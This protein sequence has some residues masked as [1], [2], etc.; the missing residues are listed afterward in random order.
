MDGI[1][2]K[3]EFMEDEFLA[4]IHEHKLLKAKYENHPEVLSDRLELR[5]VQEELER[6]RN[7]FDL[8]ERDVLLEEVQVLRSQ[9]QFYLDFSP[10]SSRK[11]NSLH[12]LTYPCEPSVPQHITVPE[13]NEES[14]EQKFERERIQWTETEKRH[15]QLL[16]RHRKV[17]VGIEDVKK[18]ATK[19]GVKGAES[20]FIN[21]LAAQKFSALRVEREKERQYF[22]DENRELQNQLRDTAEAVQ[23]AGELLAAQEAE[24][25]I[26]AAEQLP[27]K[28]DHDVY[29]IRNEIGTTYCVIDVPSKVH[30]FSIS[31]FVSLVTLAHRQMEEKNAQEEINSLNH[32]LDEPRLPKDTSEPVYDNTEAGDDRWREEF[33]PFYST[34][35]EDLPKF[36]EPSSS[37]S[38]EL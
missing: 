30:L 37:G 6:Y 2:P 35:E 13:S 1:L 23:T 18:A 16:A 11:G 25:D 32:L 26:A 4:L 28:Y 21:A 34:K 27:R 10:K 8:G 5:R 15:I 36:G 31:V 38:Q 24:E 12:N 19:A 14:S 17:Q 7:F 9:L 3:E 22:R 33:A 20:K 29:P